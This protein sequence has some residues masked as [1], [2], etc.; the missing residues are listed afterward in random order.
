[1]PMSKVAR[2]TLLYVGNASFYPINRVHIK[3]GSKLD[4]A[5]TESQAVP[6]KS[7]LSCSLGTLGTTVIFLAF[8]TSTGFIIK[9]TGLY[10]QKCLEFWV[11]VLR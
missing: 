3:V 5:P 2:P 11:L 6:S 9:I 8:E 1:M 10:L 7:R 4:C